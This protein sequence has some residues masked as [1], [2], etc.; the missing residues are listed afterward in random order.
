LVSQLDAMGL[1]LPKAK[2]LILKFRYDGDHGN[3]PLAQA[4]FDHFWKA[5]EALLSRRLEVRTYY[6]Q[7]TK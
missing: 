1:D 7:I 5:R 2:M 6:Y 3:N 4:G